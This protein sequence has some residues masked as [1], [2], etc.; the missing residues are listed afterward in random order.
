M[1][2]VDIIIPFYNVPIHYLQTALESALAQTYSD[3]KAIIVNDGSN[4]E[5]TASLE[6][7][8][9]KFPDKRIVY[10]KTE[11]RGLA[12]ARNT[13]IKASDSPYIA[14]LDSDDV[15][16][17]HKLTSQIAILE[18][19]PDISLV[20]SDVD[21]I[22]SDGHITG[23]SK[24]K[25]FSTKESHKDG[26][27]R[28]MRNNF[29]ACPTALFRR[30]SGEAVGFFDP[31][32]TSIE[33]K[34]L[35]MALLAHGYSFY[36][37]NETVAQYRMH[38]SNMSKNVEKLLYGRKLLL[39]RLS[40]MAQTN[41]LFQEIEWTRRRQEMVAHMFQEAYEG[42]KEQRKLLKALQYRYPFCL[43]MNW[44]KRA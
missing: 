16:Y 22:D 4:S 26:L 33:D 29:V 32:F 18:Q 5:S 1:A 25:D 21:I 34:M 9:K 3:W 23:K 2:Q 28:M 13:G 27:I 43:L 7:L 20:H 39:Q 35:W 31:A 11:N 15:W 12:G 17:P 8:L 6:A 44:G 37:Q 40:A 14:L 19:N 38:A 41:P 24:L 30:R 36:Y 10:L 42:Y